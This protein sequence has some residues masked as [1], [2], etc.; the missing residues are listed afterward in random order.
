MDGSNPFADPLIYQRQHVG[1]SDTEF[2]RTLHEAVDRLKLRKLT[3]SIS[4]AGLYPYA[5]EAY[6]EL[7]LIY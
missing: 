5:L 2:H 1:H 4:S 3:L 6:L 7:R